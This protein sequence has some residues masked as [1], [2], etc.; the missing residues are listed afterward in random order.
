MKFFLALVLVFSLFLTLSNCA[1]KGSGITY[2]T[3]NKNDYLVG[4]R[5][6]N[7][8][9]SALMVTGGI[10]VG[11]PYLL[12][13]MTP[14]LLINLLMSD[15]DPRVYS[16]KKINAVSQ[17]ER[18]SRIKSIKQITSNYPDECKPIISE[19]KKFIGFPEDGDCKSLYKDK[20]FNRYV[21]GGY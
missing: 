2:K 3:Y 10:A 4:Y 12:P 11:W 18:N 13:V 8:T 6:Q 17:E 14:F 1:T 20:M 9:A 19:N 15:T 5:S 21:E 16:N 7:S